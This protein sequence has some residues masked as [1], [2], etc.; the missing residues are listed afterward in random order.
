MVRLELEKERII[1]RIPSGAIVTGGGAKT[2]AIIE[3]AKRM[4]SVPVRIGVPFGVSG[5]IDDVIDPIF[6]VPIGLL[7]F[8]T[9]QEVAET[10]GLKFPIKLNLPGKGFLHK[11]IES[12][13]DLLP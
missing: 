2:I 7:L 9:K 13:K 5:L 3:S 12:V 1:N 10:S 8:G 6:S 11:I 4:L